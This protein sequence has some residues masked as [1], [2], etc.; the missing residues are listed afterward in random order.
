[1][2]FMQINP[3][4]EKAFFDF[5]NKAIKFPF[6]LYQVSF[7]NTRNH[8]FMKECNNSNE[9]GLLTCFDE[10]LNSKLFANFCYKFE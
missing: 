9:I 4:F 3:K 7:S 2:D 1:M 5:N 6:Q 10:D 8:S